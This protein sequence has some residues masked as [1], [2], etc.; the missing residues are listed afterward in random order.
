MQLTVTY[1]VDPNRAKEVNPADIPAKLVR[2]RTLHQEGELAQAKLIYEDILKTDPRNSEV[3]NLSGLIAA[4]TNNLQLAADLMDKAIECDPHNV[5]AYCNKGTLL[6]QLNKWDEALVCYDRA[7][8][9]DTN[10]AAAHYNRG[11]VLRELRE[12]HAALASY[13]RAIEINADFA[14]AQYGRGLILQVLQQNEAAL[15]S[16]DLAIAI[17]DDYAEAYSSRGHALMELGQLDAALVSL[18]RAIMIKGDYLPAYTNRGNSF[19]RLNRLDEALADFDRAIALDPDDAT[20]HYARS[21][22]LLSRGEFA[23]G[24]IEY[25]WRWKA[26]GTSTFEQKS[27][28][29]RSLHPLWLGRESIAGKNVLLYMEQGLGDAIQFC[30]YAKMA[31]AL[32]AQVI[33]EVHESL[34]V[35]LSD[36]DGVS[37]LVTRG[38]TLPAFDYQCPLLSLPL[39]FNTTIDSIPSGKYLVSDPI[40]VEHWQTKLAGLVDKTQP[41][42]GL[43]WS[44]NPTHAND[45]NRSIPF[46]DLILHLPRNYRYISLQKEVHE[47]DRAAF[48]S[49][50][51]IF[52][53][54][55]DLKDFSDT[56]AL[57]ECLDLV[58]SV[59]TSV[60]HLSGAL[61]KRTWI[62]LPFSPDWR[63]LLDRDYS[64][65]YPR[66]KLYRQ[67]QIGDWNGV[68]NQVSSDLFQAFNI[69]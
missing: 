7:I 68:L 28:F 4:Q 69:G 54:S 32:G 41:L 9:I 35:L 37:R 19:V 53:F 14:E 51:G 63:W 44:G 2:A 47:M 11:S 1:T 34:A 58:I 65:W 42:I 13:D 60:A 23:A 15:A 40:K 5:E 48:E 22:A 26:E 29:P 50:R 27:I 39:A 33:L 59:D 52:T 25:E 30:R 64:P 49:N 43:V 61:G 31:A 17:E 57:C 8:A 20:A 56:A 46:A 18:S 67:K 66:V 62:L 24:W 36:L 12:F 45:R 55:G 21:L 16:Y 38:S 10:L 3:L 6:R